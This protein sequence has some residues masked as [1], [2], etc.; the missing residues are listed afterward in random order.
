[1][2]L[3]ILGCALLRFGLFVCCGERFGADPVL[4]L[5]AATAALYTLSRRWRT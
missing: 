3:W 2:L 4:A 5:A 1:V